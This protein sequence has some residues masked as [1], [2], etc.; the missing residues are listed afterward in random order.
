[1]KKVLL[2]LSLALIS[3]TACN[4]EED[5]P[6]PVATTQTA[7][8]T[9][10][11]PTTVDKIFIRKT[12]GLGGVLVQTHSATVSTNHGVYTCSTPASLSDFHFDV[13]T[14]YHI[15]LEEL[16]SPYTIE[17]SGTITFDSAGDMSYTNTA[18]TAILTET[19]CQNVSVIEITL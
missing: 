16:V 4:K 15:K 10:P 12:N 1:M 13:G 17:W 3:L 7:V 6:V 9:P 8:V 5:Q 18:G 14:T 2:V 11:A 19:T